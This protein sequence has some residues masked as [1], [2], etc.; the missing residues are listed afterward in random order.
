METAQSKM[1]TATDLLARDCPMLAA[2]EQELRHYEEE[3]YSAYWA[4]KK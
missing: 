1:N 3:V 2:Q 4:L